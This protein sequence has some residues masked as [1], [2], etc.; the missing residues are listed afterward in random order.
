MP[1]SQLLFSTQGR[2]PRSTYWYYSFA[3]VGVYIAAIILDLA[4]GTYD[5]YSGIGIVSGLVSLA[6]IF[7]GIAVSVK[8]CHDRDHSGWFLL[9]GL[10]PFVNIWVGIELAFLRGTEGDNQ[11]GPDPI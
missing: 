2:I 8:R 4:I 9:L 11:Y 5:D 7:T 10:I 6:G 1:L 3:Y